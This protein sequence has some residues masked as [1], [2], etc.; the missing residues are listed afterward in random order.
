V[1]RGAEVPVLKIK[2][3]GGDNRAKLEREIN[4]WLAK[5]GGNVLVQ[6]TEVTPTTKSASSEPPV[7]V[8]T[9]WSEQP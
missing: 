9:V 8:V 2:R 1:E 3:F 4:I 6:R 7:I 5:Q